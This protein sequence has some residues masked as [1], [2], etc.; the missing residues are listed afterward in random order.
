MLDFLIPSLYAIVANATST[1]PTISIPATLTPIIGNASQT[2][3]TALVTSIGAIATSMFG[4]YQNNK[5]DNKSDKRTDHLANA[6]LSTVGSLQASDTASRDDAHINNL[7]VKALSTHPEL[8]KIL[9]DPANGENGKSIMDIMHQNSQEWNSS[10]AQYY[11]NKPSDP[12]TFSHDPVI[13][14]A[15]T[16]EQTTKPTPSP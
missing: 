2:D 15:A 6:Q 4:I 11:V 12:N 16:V 10:I 13:Q 9:S 1:L 8:G 14:K 7:L 5:D 3:T